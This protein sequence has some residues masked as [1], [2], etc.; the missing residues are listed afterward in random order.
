MWDRVF[1]P[2]GSGIS[3]EYA[4]QSCINL[5]VG[6]IGVLVIIMIASTS[7][8]MIYFDFNFLYEFFMFINKHIFG[9]TYVFSVVSASLFYFFTW[10]RYIYSN[11]YIHLIKKNRDNL[12]R[13]EKFV[14][15]TCIA[16]I[17][18]VIVVATIYSDLF[19]SSEGVSRRMS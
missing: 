7:I 15:L 14:D 4:F 8:S 18:L 11:R 16:L 9:S 12:R 3:K 6:L 13:Y 2:N 10:S 1:N 5:S 19:W 17:L